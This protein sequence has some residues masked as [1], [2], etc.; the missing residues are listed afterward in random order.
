MTPIDRF[1]RQLPMAL[2]DLAQPQTPDYL[3]DILGRTARTSQ[4]PAWASIERWLPVELVTSRVPATRMPWRQIGVLAL[5]AALLAALLAAYVGSRQQSLPDPFG[6]ARN[7]QI[8]YGSNGD[9]V[10]RESLTG[11]EA[12]LLGG[13]TEDHDPGLSPDGSRLMFVRTAEARDLLMVAN[14]DGTNAVQAVADPLIEPYV[15]WGPDS[16]SFA[17]VNAWHGAPKLSIVT[18]N[19]LTSR[20]IDL[21]GVLPTD[22]AWR[23]PDG[24]Q[25]LVRVMLLPTSLADSE[26]Y[27]PV[28]FVVIDFA[29]DGTITTRPMGLDPHKRFG[30]DWDNSGPVWSP[31]GSRIAYNIVAPGDGVDDGFFRVHVVNADGTGDIALPAPAIANVNEAWPIFSPDGRSILVHRWTWKGSSNG[32]AGWL[33]VMPADGSAP[34]RDIGP[35]IAGGEDTGLIK[36]WSPDGTRVLMRSGNTQQL[37]S[38]DPAT[39]ES[40]ELP[41]TS[42]SLPDWQRRAK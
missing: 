27:R 4:R 24:R 6:P 33:A 37:F 9:L 10:A 38:I 34:A 5:V 20:P 2:T 19:G 28:D 32:G 18:L 41:W 23:P 11:Q 16:D 22:L 3:T 13:P 15:A 17:I 1:E 39:G 31:D 29:A 8:V 14:V 30:G 25:L 7:G 42:P 36:A 40:E 21:G 35:R 12:V 26:I